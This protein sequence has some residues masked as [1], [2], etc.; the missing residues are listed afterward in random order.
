MMRRTSRG[1]GTFGGRSGVW[2]KVKPNRLSVGSATSKD[3]VQ[4]ARLS[5]DS[6]VVS[7]SSLPLNGDRDE[8]LSMSSS[9]SGGIPLSLVRDTS[10]L[11]DV[12]SVE[13][14]T[15][16]S[17]ESPVTES[18]DADSDLAVDH[19]DDTIMPPTDHDNA[20]P[21]LPKD[22]SLTID[23]LPMLQSL[24]SPSDASS[25]HA[26][27]DKAIDWNMVNDDTLVGWEDGMETATKENRV[28]Y[29]DWNNESDNDSS[30]VDEDSE[31]KDDSDGNIDQGKGDDPPA[32]NATAF[33][34][35]STWIQS[36]RNRKFGGKTR[37]VKQSKNGQEQARVKE[38]AQKDATKTQP[39]KGPRTKINLKKVTQKGRVIKRKAD[40]MS[41][42]RTQKE[43]NYFRNRF[44]HVD[45]EV[46]LNVE[47][48]NKP[49]PNTRPRRQAKKRLN[50]RSNYTPTTRRENVSRTA[51]S[52]NN[53]PT[54]KEP[55]APIGNAGD[56]FERV[57]IRRGE[58]GLRELLVQLQENTAAE[59]PATLP[60]GS[61]IELVITNHLAPREM[62]ILA[63]I[64]R[65][66]K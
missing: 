44:E 28:D 41:T 37:L 9:S 39:A 58:D 13:H 12:S 46:T 66:G 20:G 8:G 53:Q 32:A 26:E 57:T 54:P 3:T 19:N 17:A 23:P 50:L 2:W 6:S 56:S 4:T 43:I 16:K 63:R 22:S 59:V 51:A 25:V 42:P 35:P 21:N 62:P 34:S 15:A 11:S 52:A 45:R 24:S 18:D 7:L 61:M 48:V 5:L 60:P 40:D 30:S 36:K 31:I 1:R 55:T 14:D 33:G 49:L 65:P 64:R 47:C 29:L 10:V 27:H 38:M